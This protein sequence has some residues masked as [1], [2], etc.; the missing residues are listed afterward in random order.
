MPTYEYFCTN[1]ACFSSQEEEH[2][3]IGFKEYHPACQACGSECKYHFVPSVIQFAL[4]DG[5]SGSWPSKGNHFKQYRSKRAEEMEKRQKDRYGHLSRDAKPNYN[6]QVTETWREA[7]SL[8]MQ[9]KDRQEATGTDSIAVGHT[10][11]E[12]IK[13]EGSKLKI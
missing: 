11:K 3:I 2:S 13:K 7:Q 1:D 10:Y 9:D 12:K 8:A 4:K 6:G 5:P